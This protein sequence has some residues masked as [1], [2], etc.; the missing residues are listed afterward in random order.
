MHLHKSRTES[1][2]SNGR[3]AISYDNNY[4]SKAIEK[5]MQ[6]KYDLVK[7]LTS[8]IATWK[9]SGLL[10]NAN[11]ASV[12]LQNVETVINIRQVIKKAR[13]TYTRN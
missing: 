3:F 12:S 2:S 1:F 8:T 6:I 10:E 11:N 9:F 5:L 4:C 13:Y 7:V